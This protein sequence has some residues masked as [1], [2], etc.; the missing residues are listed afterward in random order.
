[1]NKSKANNKEIQICRY[2]GN[3]ISGDDIRYFDDRILCTDC[4]DNETTFCHHCGERIWRDENVGTHDM[5]LCQTCYDAH[6]TTCEHC[7]RII[8]Q[9]SAHYYDDSDYPYCDDCWHD[10]NEDEDSDVIHK[11]NYKPEPIF[12]GD[13]TR[14]FGVELEIDCGGNCDDN[15]E[16]LLHIGNKYTESIYI[17]SDGSLNDGMEIVTYPMTLEY[18]KT[19]MP[20]DEICKKAIS[21]GYKSHRTRTCGLHIHVNRDTF[22]RTR[23]AQ[24]NAISRV[25]YFVEHHWNELLRFSRRTETQMSKWAARYGYKNKPKDILDHA[26]SSGDNRYTCVNITNYDTIEFRMFRGTLKYNTLIATLELVDQICEYAIRNS[27]DDLARISWSEF[28]IS[29]DKDDCAELITYLKQRRLYVNPPIDD[30]EDD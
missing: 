6:Y 14:F 30:E 12:Y 29:L 8:Y 11:Y 25:L 17:K 10:D 4:L 24:E 16:S 26:K 28:V 18:H 19:E 13:D 7:G 20:W 23:E 22:G 5:P 21:M 27:D 9:D 3:E 2:C 15:A 1:M